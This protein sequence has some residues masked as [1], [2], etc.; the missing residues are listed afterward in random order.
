M[1]FQW[2][3]ESFKQ[4]FTWTFSTYIIQSRCCSYLEFWTINWPNFLGS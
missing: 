2:W 1:L 3:L 4:F